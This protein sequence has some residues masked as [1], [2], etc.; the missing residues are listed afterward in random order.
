MSEVLEAG[1]TTAV[2]V[3]TAATTTVRP[4]LPTARNLAVDAYRGLVMLLMMGEVL[5]FSRVSAYFHDSVFWKVLAFNQSHTEWFGCFL[6]DMNQPFF[7][8]LGWLSPPDS[9]R[10]RQPKGTPFPRMLGHTIW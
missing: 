4:D 1:A 3:Q 7:S 8:L 5:S 9:I 10:D 2:K 6:P